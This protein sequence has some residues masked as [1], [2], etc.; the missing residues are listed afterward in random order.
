MADFEDQDQAG[1]REWLARLA[2]QLERQYASAQA[3]EGRCSWGRLLAVVAAALSW[4]VPGVWVSL[5]LVIC[6]GFLVAF[7]ALVRRH[8]RFRFQRLQIEGERVVAKESL[9]RAGGAVVLIRA[10]TRPRQPLDSSA[11]LTPCATTGVTFS[12][13]TQELE[14]LDIYAQ[15]VGLFGLLNRCSTRL[16]ARRLR[17]ILENPLLEAAPIRRRQKNVASLADNDRGRLS[18]LGSLARLRRMDD[19]MDRMVTA[20][21]GVEPLGHAIG[22]TIL[23]IAS[24]LIGIAILVSLALVINGHFAATAGFSLMLINLIAWRLLRPTLARHWLAW[25]ELSPVAALLGE[26][27]LGAAS[28]DSGA[29]RTDEIESLI[30]QLQKLA[31]FAPGLSRRLGWLNI[32]GPM[33]GVVNALI[34]YDLHAVWAVNRHAVRHGAQMIA[35]LRAMAEIEA[36]LSL[37]AFARES[38]GPVCCPT[39]VEGAPQLQIQAGRHPLID[40]AHAVAND[41]KLDA[42]L[43]LALVTGSNMSGKSTY[44]RMVGVN[45]LLAQIGAPV[46]A[47]EITLSPSRIVTDLNVSD[48][49]G[50]GESYFLAEVRHVRRLIEASPD[51]TCVLGLLDEPFRGTNSDE[52]LACTAAVLEYINQ[53]GKLSIVAT[54]EQQLAAL[55]EQMPGATNFHFNETLGPQGLSF[56][57]RMK[58]GRATT[59][60]AI[61]VLAREAYPPEILERARQICRQ[62]MK[63]Q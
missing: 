11:I 28:E 20:L 50:G 43:R 16:G 2:V 42:S 1:L 55:V 44:L 37:A 9:R 21:L 15:P 36:L 51:S 52:R 4:I 58:N 6:A 38:A 19:S 23:S 49:L 31:A 60:N 39:I 62:G 22:F 35:G 34:L 7:A 56:D 45:C 8:R 61:E 40:P 57:Y 26:A 27:A 17:D 47:R 63:P 29:P 53:P 13:T 14:D 54:H 18:A 10:G 46:L 59:R 32:G 25:R 48:S 30:S 24:I 5:R 33:H 41:V 12:L 3:A